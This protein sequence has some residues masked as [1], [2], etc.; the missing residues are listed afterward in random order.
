MCSTIT[1]SLGNGGGSPG[2][3]RLT[4]AWY[5]PSKFLRAI[6]ESSALVSASRTATNAQGWL[7]PP[8]GAF[9]AASITFSIRSSGTGSGLK[10]RMARWL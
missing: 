7:L 3:A 5:I 8:L 2:W 4:A 10:L 9:V 1:L 6:A